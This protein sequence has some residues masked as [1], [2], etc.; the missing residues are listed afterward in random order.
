MWLPVD[1]IKKTWERA[2][3]F[4][5]MPVGDVMKKRHKSPHPVLNVHRRDEAV[6]ALWHPGC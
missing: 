1:I 4:A 5:K 3:Q 2:A 6:A